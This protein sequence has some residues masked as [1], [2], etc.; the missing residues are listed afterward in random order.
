MKKRISVSIFV[1][2]AFFVA[3]INAKLAIRE[4]GAHC[5]V[6]RC[7]SGQGYNRPISTADAEDEVNR[8]RQEAIKAYDT[9][10]YMA[11]MNGWAEKRQRALDIQTKLGYTVPQNYEW[12]D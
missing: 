12:G 4:R 9:G 5:H 11:G 8:L 1:S 7:F 3:I 2:I 6:G 10:T